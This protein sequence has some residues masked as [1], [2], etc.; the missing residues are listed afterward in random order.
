[1]KAWHIG[2]FNEVK[3]Q[4]GTLEPR[5]GEIKVKIYKV[6]LSAMDVSCFSQRENDAVTI[7]A[8]AAIAHV[9]DDY[10][11][12][13]F[14]LGSRVVISP[15]LNIEE[16]GEMVQKTMGIDVD[17][18]M[19]DFVSVPAENV[20]NLP[21]G[22]ADDD[23]VFADYIAMGNKVFSALSCD[24]GDYVVIVGAGALGL[25]LC[26]LAMY[27]QMV[28]VLVDLDEDKLNLAKR[29]GVYYTLNPTFDN[30]ERRVEQITGGRMC[31]GAIFTTDGVGLNAALRL[32]KNGS[33]IIIAGHSASNK[34]HVDMNIIMKKQLIVKGVCN[35]LNEMPSAINLLANRIVNTDGII[36][37]TEN[38]EDL[39]RIYDECL[40]YPYKYN[41]VMF[42]AD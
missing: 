4:E 34:H 23:A 8:H 30:L 6:A 14:K 39:P 25:I 17:G 13:G 2:N 5:E 9:A 22:I 28:P 35:G 29:C 1:M 16:H 24:S 21:D 10:Q 36:T 3:L 41:T 12:Q 37:A 20:F 42:V 7:P 38:F 15:Y 11:E 31:E 27:Y 26:Q 40:N 33:E 18:L 19:Q 32:V